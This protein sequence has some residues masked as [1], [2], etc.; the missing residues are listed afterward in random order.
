[1]NAGRLQL[2]LSREIVEL[3]SDKKQIG[4]YSLIKSSAVRITKRTPFAVMAA[5]AVVASEKLAGFLLADCFC[6]MCRVL[7]ARLLFSRAYL[8]FS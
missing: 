1:M 8:F 6:Q 5:I 4:S 3:F 2:F 7:R